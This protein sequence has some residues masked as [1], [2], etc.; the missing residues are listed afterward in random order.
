M[1]KLKWNAALLF[2][3]KNRLRILYN[4]KFRIQ[5][6]SQPILSHGRSFVSAENLK[7]SSTFPQDTK[8][9]Q[10]ESEVFEIASYPE[11]KC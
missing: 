3:E 6:I 8:L 1:R 9:F 2:L 5:R 4:L 11:G 10:N 7:I